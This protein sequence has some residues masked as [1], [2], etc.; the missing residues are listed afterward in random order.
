MSGY[1]LI[2]KLHFGSLRSVLAL[3]R[4][5]SALFGQFRLCIGPFCFFRSFLASFRSVPAVFGPFRYLFG[6][7]PMF[8]RV[9]SS[10][11]IYQRN[12]ELSQFCLILEDFKPKLT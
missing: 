4:S 6:P 9:E 5:V 7:F 8:Q 11:P 3:Y 12:L 2:V 10:K 1:L